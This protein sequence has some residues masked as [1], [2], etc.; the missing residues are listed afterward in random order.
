LGARSIFS[1]RHISGDRACR[2]RSR[3]RSPTA[4]PVAWG[5]VRGCRIRAVGVARRS[6]GWPRVC[7]RNSSSMPYIP[8]STP[9]PKAV[10]VFVGEY[11][12]F[13][14]KPFEGTASP[15]SFARPYSGRAGTAHG[16]PQGNRA[17]R[18]IIFTPG[19]RRS[20]LIDCALLHA[21]WPRPDRR[22]RRRR[23]NRPYRPS[24]AS[25]RTSPPTP[26]IEAIVP[27]FERSSPVV[28][29]R[30]SGSIS[31][32]APTIFLGLQQIVRFP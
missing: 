7:D 25:S 27:R 26:G 8:P 2:I 6:G 23:C 10:T 14:R 12:T 29:G 20:V 16:P 28:Y 32:L 19:E 4:V 15:E 30:K 21:P 24:F 11:K 9:A 22:R 5:N 1:L 31:P 18:R 3:T 17:D 13:G